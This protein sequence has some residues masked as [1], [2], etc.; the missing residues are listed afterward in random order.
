MATLDREL[1]IRGNSWLAYRQ[2]RI[3]QLPLTILLVEF[4]DQNWYL[5]T[6]N[7]A[8]AKRLKQTRNFKL[9][10]QIPWQNLNVWIFGTVCRNRIAVTNCVSG[11]GGYASISS[12]ST[13]CRQL[14]YR[15]A[16]QLF[17]EGVVILLEV[18]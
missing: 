8:L 14:F 10:N 9:R 11:C 2:S 18:P 6:R 4:D 7:E 16:G 17:Y 13:I 5:R 15:T 12:L 3:A 1:P